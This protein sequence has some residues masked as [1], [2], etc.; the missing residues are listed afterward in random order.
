MGVDD[1]VGEHPE[2][3]DGLD[4][5]SAGT[6]K[7]TAEGGQHG[8]E[9]RVVVALDSCG[10]GR[11]R[12]RGEGRGEQM[13]HN[14]VMGPNANGTILVLCVRGKPRLLLRTPCSHTKQVGRMDVLLWPLDRPLHQYLFAGKAPTHTKTYPVTSHTCTRKVS[15]L[16]STNTEVCT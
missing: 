12:K 9:D 2:V 7:A 15:L 5:S 4:L 3:Q 8:Q 16:F 1:P 6:V 14:M 10:R 13:T 11:V